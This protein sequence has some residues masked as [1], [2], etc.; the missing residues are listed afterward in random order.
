MK[1]RPIVFAQSDHR[2][3]TGAKTRHGFTLVELLVVISIIALLVAL[4]LPA[5]GGIRVKAKETQTTAM[6]NAIDSAINLFRGEQALGGA[7][8][9]SAS[10]NM[11]DTRTIADPFSASVSNIQIT[12]AHLLA[13]ALVG[14][15]LRGTPGFKDVDRNGVWWNDT[16]KM[17]GASASMQGLYAVD[18]TTLD[19]RHTRYPSSSTYVDDNMR[20]KHVTSL[21]KMVDTSKIFSWT[22]STAPPTGTVPTAGT[23]VQPLFVDPWERPILYYRA[24][25]AGKRMLWDS[26]TPGVYR[27][28]DNEIIT[29]SKQGGL[30]GIDFGGGEQLVGGAPAGFM[31][32]IGDDK[33]PGLD[34]ATVR[35]Q[36]DPT[37]D[38][39]LAKF[40]HDQKV[41]AT[42]QPVK[43]DSYLLISAGDDA[44]YGTGDDIVNWTKE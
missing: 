26:N 39:T 2:L 43:K 32:N 22:D 34:P 10:D 8:P 17:D 23:S 41:T 42:N 24:N 1:M 19:P 12:G 27:H 37:F 9:P 15:D 30:K 20:N 18:A 38:G 31:S 3:Q 25:K 5:F 4:L 11:T 40:I 33:S 6:F 35:I 44:V 36:E 16:H 14:A 13:Q 7:L 29:G 21:Q 28:K